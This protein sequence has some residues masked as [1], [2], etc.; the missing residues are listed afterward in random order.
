M[1]DVDAFIAQYDPEAR[2]RPKIAAEIA[3]RL[4]AAGRAG[5]ALSFVDRAEFREH[6]WVPPEW[7]MARLNALEALDRADEAQTFRLECFHHSLSVDHLRAYLKR[8]PDFEDIEAEDGAIAY[9]M[10]YPSVLSAFH[11]LI[12]WPALDRAAQ[13]VQSRFSELDGDHYELLTP[14]AE[15]LSARYPLAATLALRAMIDFT[16]SAGKS[17]RYQHAARH[18]DECDALAG[19]IEDFGT[20]EPHDAYVA[21][22]RLDHARKAGFWRRVA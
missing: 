18:L 11:F 13:L 10:T 8:L 12:R 22:L 17:S 14:A 4:L 15:A 21:R 20:L 7:Q 3:A 5:D 2:K 1:G 19:Q 6:S 16:L 9:V